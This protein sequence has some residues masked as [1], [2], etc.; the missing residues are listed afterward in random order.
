M[1]HEAE[2]K[3]LLLRMSNDLWLDLVML[4]DKE[5]RSVN[6]QIEYLLTQCVNKMK[7]EKKL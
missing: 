5:F 7:E 6:S 1:E 4:A 2:Q 3:Q